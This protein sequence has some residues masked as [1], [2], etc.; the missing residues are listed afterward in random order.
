MSV[1]ASRT[2]AEHAYPSFTFAASSA[3]ELKRM[4]YD[5]SPAMVIA[6]AKD[7]TYLIDEIRATWNQ[8]RSSQKEL[9]EDHLLGQQATT[10]V[11]KRI[12]TLFTVASTAFSSDKRPDYYWPV[13]WEEGEDDTKRIAEILDFW[14]KNEGQV[15]AT[16]ASNDLYHMMEAWHKADRHHMAWKASRR[17]F[18]PKKETPAL[19]AARLYKEQFGSDWGKQARGRLSS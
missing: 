13:T 1:E 11:Q 16:K 4:S 12:I 3:N 10:S 17:L 14:I 6:R 9:P 18:K 2:P 7:I 5:E 8:L 15:T 19:T